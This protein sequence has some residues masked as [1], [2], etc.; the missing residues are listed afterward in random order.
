[1]T[2]NTGERSRARPDD[3]TGATL[4][5]HVGHA[6]PA[7]TDQWKFLMNSTQTLLTIDFDQTLPAG[8]RV[9]ISGW[10]KNRR[11]EPGPSGMPVSVC[12]GEGICS[13]PQTAMGRLWFARNDDAP[14]TNHGL[15]AAGAVVG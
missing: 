5:Y 14:Q 1:V 2:S 9:W 6:P 15:A 3:A 13:S 12:V 7:Q 11:S 10:W 8:T 4:F